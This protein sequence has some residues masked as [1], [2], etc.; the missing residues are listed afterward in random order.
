MEK[1][2]LI[3]IDNNATTM[4][5]PEVFDVMKPFLTEYYGNPSSIYSF[6]EQVAVYLS[7]AKNQVAQLLGAQP[8]EIIFTSCGT[9]SDST[10]IYSALSICS[11]K[12]KIITSKVEHPAVLNLCKYLSDKGY[13]IVE[14]PV[15]KNGR[16]DVKR[17][18]DAV[19]NNT[20][21]VSIM[22]ANN[23]IG[24]IYPV[25]EIAKAV[26]AKGA[27]FH[28]DAVQ[29]VGKIPIDLSNSE[30]DMLS[31]SGHKIHA[32]KGVGALYIRKGVRFNP[33]M[34]GGHQEDGRRAGTENNASI[35]GLGKACELAGQHMDYELNDVK[36]MRDFLETELVRRIP[37][38]KINGDIKNRVPNT[39]NV[40]FEGIEGE[41]ILLIL[42][43]V[44][45]IAASSG[46]AC[47]TGSLQP[48][49]VL[50]AIDLPYTL[51]HSSLRL[52][53]SRFN[54]MKEMEKVVET[55][56]FAVDK[57]RAISPYWK[58]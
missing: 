51:L 2:D 30:I 54:T 58:E 33:F 47:T 42:D 32:P 35:I 44:A 18:E 1:K 40:S 45:N 11:H 6:G 49:H 31:M 50:T 21:L 28:T 16:I 23:E 37:K 52:S 36:K 24:N 3:Y 55:I 10:A 4:I 53:L 26:H 38:T 12:N 46:S 57:L 29:A 13:E 20:A 41:S 17:I 8:E 15:D 39:T 5:D 27:L 25:E 34:I 14:I 43:K 19:D 56:V 48:S 7:K 22:W 9:E